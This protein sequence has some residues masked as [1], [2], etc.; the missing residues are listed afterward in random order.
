MYVGR[1]WAGRG[2]GCGSRCVNTGTVG[3]LELRALHTPGLTLGTGGYFL[4]LRRDRA[5]DKAP[6]SSPHSILLCGP[7]LSRAGAARC[8]EGEHT[9][10]LLESLIK[11]IGALPADTELFYSHEY[12]LR[13][14]EFAS[15]LAGGR[16]A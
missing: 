7:T 5:V 4:S 3:S 10:Y 12:A 2:C 14:L 13:N 1:L 11:R 9:E 6:V 16:G 15:Y 8:L